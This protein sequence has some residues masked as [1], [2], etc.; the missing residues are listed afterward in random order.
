MKRGDLVTI[1]N[2]GYWHGTIGVIVDLGNNG[3]PI[4]FFADVQERAPIIRRSLKV[5]YESR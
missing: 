1:N 5:I 2:H 3:D 4:V